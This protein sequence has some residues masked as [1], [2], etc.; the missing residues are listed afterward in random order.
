ML[1]PNIASVWLQRWI[2][3][4]IQEEESWKKALRSGHFSQYSACIENWTVR[5]FLKTI[6]IDRAHHEA[7]FDHKAISVH[8]R[9]F[10]TISLKRD[11]ENSSISH[12]NIDIGSAR[13]YKPHFKIIR[14]IPFCRASKT[15][16]IYGISFH[17]SIVF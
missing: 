11:D 2:H 5:I 12:T 6:P 4:A 10:N 8:V 15:T 13:L 16:S 3:N 17:I 1:I 9:F 7:V 14:N